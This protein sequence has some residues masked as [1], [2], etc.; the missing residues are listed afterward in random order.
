MAQKPMDPLA[1]MNLMGNAA[2]AKAHQNTNPD[3]EEDPLNSGTPKAKKSP[4]SIKGKQVAAIKSQ[5]KGKGNSIPNNSN[6]PSGS[7]FPQSS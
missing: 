2:N 4:A 1:I 3:D 6:G 5:Q 7:N